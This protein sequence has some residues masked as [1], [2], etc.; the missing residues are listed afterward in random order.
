MPSSSFTSSPGERPWPAAR[1]RTLHLSGDVDEE[2]CAELTA[3][4]HR[5]AGEADAGP[6]V[7][8]ELSRAVRL[9]EA[10]AHALIRLVLAGGE[11]HPRV[12]LTGEWLS[13][14][15]LARHRSEPAGAPGEEAS[16]LERQLQDLRASLLTRP[17]I[18]QAQ[19]VLQERYALSASVSTF[20]LLRES[21]QRHNIK[22]RSLAAAFLSAPRPP[23]EVPLWFPGRKRAPVP[24]LDFARQME[25]S[26]VPRS[27]LAEAALRAALRGT[28]SDWGL[29]QVV[30]PVI[31]LQLEADHEMPKELLDLL[32]RVPEPD[33]QSMAARALEH[34]VRIDHVEDED[35]SPFGEGLGRLLRKAGV[36]RA[37]CAPLLSPAG[38]R[39]GVITVFAPVGRDRL[40]ETE[41]KALDLIAAQTG[42]WLDWHR[43]TV[44]MD[45]LEFLHRRARTLAV[46]LAT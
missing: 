13:H 40:S 43:R 12:V 3:R 30:D 1:V 16:V 35:G 2:D 15:D 22:L 46:P 17:L 19:G 9:S 38:A 8:L 6:F 28:R 41:S 34:G 36:G 5:L 24:A 4:I 42:A 21:S 39:T 33:E 45:A 27:A 23:G 18:A 31:G 25:R 29:L 14:P 20:D 7:A 44:V 26:R 10:A 11:R 37:H 32:A